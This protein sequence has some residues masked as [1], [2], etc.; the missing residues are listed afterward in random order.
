M[1]LFD[2]INEDL[3]SAMKAREK[4]KLEAIR[5]IKKVL[6]EAKAAKGAN[7]ELDDQ[8]VMKVISKLAK[9]GQ[10]SANIYKEQARPDLYEAEMA[11]VKVYEQYLPKKLSDDELAAAIQE[12]IASVGASGMKDMGKV[13]G[14]AS[15]QLAGKAE[16][17][18]IADKVKSLLN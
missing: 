12:I 10:D 18:D 15:K 16:G 11:Q 6:L 8:E 5:N 4:E 2:Q 13:M 1:N 7:A 14:V 9:Q 17:K 3:K